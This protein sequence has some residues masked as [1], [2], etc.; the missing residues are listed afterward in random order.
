[1]YA[2]LAAVVA[3]QVTMFFIFLVKYWEDFTLV[4]Q[5]KGTEPYKDD[6]GNAINPLTADGKGTLMEQVF[7][8]KTKSI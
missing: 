2:G 8:K 5:G 7:P 3:T 4:A 1:M 6:E